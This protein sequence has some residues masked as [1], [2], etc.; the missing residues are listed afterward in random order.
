MIG[1]LNSIQNQQIITIDSEAYDICR[2][3][4]RQRKKKRLEGI[5][6]FLSLLRIMMLAKSLK[7]IR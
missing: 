1:L 3:L 2:A 5:D 4:I 6:V 7:Y